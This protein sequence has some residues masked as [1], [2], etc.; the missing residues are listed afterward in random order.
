MEEIKEK[1]EMLFNLIVL[2]NGNDIKSIII[3]SI[4]EKDELL[5]YQESDGIKTTRKLEEITGISRS[6]IS[7]CWDKW[8]K[9]GIMKKKNNENRGIRLFDLELLEIDFDS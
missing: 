2:I 8:T 1:L 9:L 5:L 4:E 6:K 7:T 3:E